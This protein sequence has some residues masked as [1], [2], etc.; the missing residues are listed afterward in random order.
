MMSTG[1]TEKAP[2]EYAVS[3][4]TLGR[5]EQLQETLH[6]IYRQSFPPALIVIV[7]NNDE[8]DTFTIP[9]PVPNTTEILTVLHDKQPRSDA[10]GSQ[11]ALDVFNVRGF[12]I[13]V[14]W[15]DDLIPEDTCF[16][17]L[18]D[19]VVLGALAAGGMYPGRMQGFSY[20]KNNRVFSGDGNP[21]HIQFFPWRGEHIKLLNEHLYSSFAY[22]IEAANLVG[23]FCTEYFLYRHETEFSMRL[24]QIASYSTQ[25]KENLIIDTS[26]VADHKRLTKG[27]TMSISPK[28]KEEKT[29][30]DYLLFRDRI[31]WLG[32]VL[33]GV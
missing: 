19:H 4:A 5:D 14:K 13:A 2:V 25:R 23:G 16:E 17:K 31:K 11:I 7:D 12:K 29:T 10:T 20:V 26:A 33:E 24:N 21:N 9:K 3:I 1:T 18:V 28:E 30:H 6:A 22:N 8:P 32:L 27:G 15:D